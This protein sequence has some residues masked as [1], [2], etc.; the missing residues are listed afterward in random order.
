V[1]GGEHVS[2]AMVSNNLGEALNSL[3][4]HTEARAAFTKALEIWRRA[5][6]DAFYLGYGLT[7]QGI[8]IL[9]E[10]KA[11]EAITPLEEALKIRVDK[12]ADA[13]HMGETRFALARALWSQ[14]AARD[15]ARALATDA[16]ENYAQVKTGAARV[17]AVDAWL[18][19][20]AA[21]L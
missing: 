21:R 10:G 2:V 20:P 12:K 15:R 11:A 7:G 8:A 6:S 13:E 19:A 9:G 16:R 17:A 5:G 1:F 4:R 14:A 18:K 3:Q